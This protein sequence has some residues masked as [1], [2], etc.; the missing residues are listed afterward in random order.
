MKPSFALNLSHDGISLLHRASNGWQVVGEVS[1]DNENLSARLQELHKSAAGLSL[2]GVACKLVIPASQVL[3]KEF[4]APGPS[5]AEC[6]VQI[7]KGLDGLT[8]YEVDE[9]AFD[10]QRV[11]DD[12]VRVAAVAQETLS[13]AE[14]FALEHRLNPVSF[15]A[16]PG[17]GQFEGEPFFGN[18]RSAS[19]WLDSSDPLEPDQDAIKILGTFEDRSLTDKPPVTW[20]SP[21]AKSEN[22]TAPATDP[23]T[24][25]D[26]PVIED[27]PAAS[28]E[29]T[30]AK[31]PTKIPSAGSAS[32]IANSGAA[33]NKIPSP[34]ADSDVP[35]TPA[36]AQKPPLATPAP[37]FS[38]ARPPSKNKG[39]RKQKKSGKDT[40]LNQGG[41]LE[42]QPSRI[43][44]TA[45]PQSTVSDK[46]VVFASKRLP[47]SQKDVLPDILAAAASLSP[48]PT[49]EN[50]KP[51]ASKLRRKRRKKSAK[52]KTKSKTAPIAKS[53]IVAAPVSPVPSEGLPEQESLTV[54]GARNPDQK[55]TQ[56]R[57]KRLIIAGALIGVLI[58]I[59][60]ATL[61][62]Y[63]DSLFGESG[64]NAA[65]IQPTP[66]DETAGID[67]AALP[68]GDPSILPE[69]AL[70]EG[71]EAELPNPAPIEQPEINLVEPD[72]IEERLA[73][74]PETPNILLVETLLPEGLP[75]VLPEPLPEEIPVPA[76]EDEINTIPEILEPDAPELSPIVK[77][78]IPD[79]GAIAAAQLLQNPPTR[80]A[81]PLPDTTDN[82]YIASIDQ[83]S[84]S[85]DA[86]ALPEADSFSS[87]LALLAV[88][89]PAPPGSRFVLDERGLVIP[90][91]EGTLNPDGVIIYA[92]KPPAAPALRV[93]L[94]G[95][96]DK[97]NPDDL[98][99]KR[100]KRRPVDLLEKTEKFR[101]GGRTLA[102]LATLRPA[103]RPRSLQQ[104]ATPSDPTPTTLAVLQSS[105]PKSRP[106][107]FAGLVAAV[108]AQQEAATTS[109]G[110]AA[111]VATAPTLAVPVGPTIP[112]SASV[113]RQATVTN[114]LNLRK[115]NLIGVYG[116]P[117]SRR[118]LVR[119]A[120]GRYVKLKVGD[121]VDGGKV[122]AI[123][124][125]QLIYVKRGRNITLKMPKT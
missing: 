123:G 64:D 22:I 52:T 66:A 34:Q 24:A 69:P 44:M 107:A 15:V 41:Q 59:L 17:A 71:P 39:S 54:F 93:A 62:L 18:A 79:P 94:E 3:Y 76:L 36:S 43:T 56:R 121:R 48:G 102:Q 81:P 12:M 95:D 49:A 106:D 84:T 117:S 7:R 114:V 78:D 103:L 70:I 125:D 113:A 86:I 80:N 115:I 53:T 20:P 9:L 32:R 122:A 25:P 74:L 6:L 35:S 37:A 83:S 14:S 77:G 10:W 100:P 19:D 13:E 29:P 40:V 110:A 28:S 51:S 105:N 26:P 72:P 87:D 67:F 68:E 75:E 96:P 98:A 88:P 101:L 47:T 85:H 124:P 108:R 90:T 97:S 16:I 118:A 91:P 1:L 119:L 58:V 112:S 60:I 27:V 2:G 82:L 23:V 11:S 21:D 8:P 46:S 116:S 33:E 92:G 61:V 5:K 63:K 50:P 55:N 57:R 30:G 120:S 73:S 65:L 31:I 42:N 104:A 89:N 4:K 99:K 111:T 38:S 109:A 45:E